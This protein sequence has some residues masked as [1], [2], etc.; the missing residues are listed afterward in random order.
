[1]SV[2]APL[3]LFPTYLPFW[4]Y[5]PLAPQNRPQ[6]GDSTHFENHRSKIFM[7]KRL[8]KMIKI[9]LP[10]NIYNIYK[11][12][13]FFCHIAEF[14]LSHNR[15][16]F[17]RRC[18][19]F[20]STYFFCVCSIPRLNDGLQPLLQALINSYNQLQKIITP[21]RHHLSSSCCFLLCV[22]A[23]ANLSTPFSRRGAFLY[24]GHISALM[25]CAFLYRGH[26][27]ALMFCAFFLRNSQ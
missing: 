16:Q 6:G 21:Q 23:L 10:I 13:C 11:S 15:D 2:F 5:P 3:L 24:R 19:S 20:S 9:C 8:R 1:L 25:F 14:L 26:I 18:V 7:T 4:F 17:F 22:S 27:S 12:L